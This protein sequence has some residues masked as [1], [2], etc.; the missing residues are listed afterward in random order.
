MNLCFLGSGKNRADIEGIEIDPVVQ[1]LRC[2]YDRL[3]FGG[4]KSG[5]MGRFAQA[6]RN[7]GG[8]IISVVPGWL[9]K[10]DGGRFVFKGDD[11]LYCENT[12]KTKS[13]MFGKADGIIC[14]PGGLGTLD[15]LFSYLA[16]QAVKER[17]ALDL[18]LY[19]YN[20][21]FSPL[22]AQLEMGIEMGLIKKRSLSKFYPF[23]NSQQLKDLLSAQGK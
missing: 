2:R 11:V 17:K 6:F 20:K 12:E 7:A 3:F 14:Y 22:L 23:E 15:E 1:A 13:R 19:N 5:L 4:S 9:A 10:A 16:S 21:Y 8:T 18:Y